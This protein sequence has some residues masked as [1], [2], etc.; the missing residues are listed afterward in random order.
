[1]SEMQANEGEPS[2][3]WDIF[4]HVFDLVKNGNQAFRENRFEEAINCYSRANNIKPCDPVILG[5]RCAAYIRISKF[6]RHIPASASE[7]RARNGLDPTTHA[8]LALKDVEK[9]MNLRS[10]SEKA[11][12]LKAEALVL[13]ERYDM[14]RDV[15][16]SGLQV[17]PFSLTSFVSAKGNDSSPPTATFSPSDNFLIDCG[18]SQQTKLNDGRT[19]KSDRDTSSLLSTNEDVQA[20]VDS[21]TANA[22]SNIASSSQPLYR[23]ARIFSEKSTYTFYINKPGQHW[24]RLYFHPL[25]HQTYNLT[26]AVFTV[27]TDKYV[28]L[29]DFSVTDSTTLVFKEYILNVT[30]NRISLHFSPKKKSCAFVNAIEVVSAPD[31]LFNNSATSVSP[32]GDFNGLSNYAFQ[33]Q[34][35]LNVGGPLL[36]PANDTLSR[37]WEPDNAYNAFPQGTQNVSV[38]PKAI[39]YP[40][41]GAT[42]L[43]APN[44]VYASAQHMK[45]SATSQQNFNLTWKLNVEEDFSYLIRMHFSDIVSKALNTLYF[46]VYVNGMSAVSNLDLSS[47]T[48]GLSTAYYKDFVL[49]ATSISSENNTIR[50]QVGPGSTQ[51]GSQDALLNGLE[52]LKMSNIADSLDGLFGVDGSYKGPTGISTMKI[53]AGVGLGMGLTAMLLVVVVIVRWKRRPQAN[54]AYSPVRAAQE[55]Q[56]SSAH[57]RAKVVTQPIS[58]QLIATEGF[59]TCVPDDNGETGPDSSES[60]G[61]KEDSDD[62]EEDD[63]DGEDGDGDNGTTLKTNLSRKLAVGNC[64]IIGSVF[65]YPHHLHAQFILC[66]LAMG[67]DFC[68]LGVGSFQFQKWRNLVEIPSSVA[69]IAKILLRSVMILYPKSLCNCGEVLGWKYVRA[70]DISQKYKEGKFIIERAKIAKEY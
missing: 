38:A 50:V 18:S 6:L 66:I 53:V 54:L 44:L 68:F 14:A 60:E 26:S 19:F 34:Y 51:S 28:L 3:P 45:D 64:Q 55:D 33:V 5:N 9:L 32:V 48:G 37:T 69:E 15:I 52:I 36:S 10:N 70:Y 46:N 49:N 63:S 31:T 43:I 22:S 1:M 57:A 4:S 2:L 39:K 11:F 23:T 62:D 27:N 13:L 29:H 25:P 41:S 67:S 65:L 59:R 42:V 56:A 24:I 17:D 7:Y 20:S 30:E 35:R 12:I 16:L 58:L 47:L 21:I 40:E 61:E 8:E